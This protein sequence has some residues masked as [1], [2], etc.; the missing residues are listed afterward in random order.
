MTSKDLIQAN[1]IFLA[2]DPLLETNKP[3]ELLYDTPEIPRGANFDEITESV[4]IEDFRPLKGKLSLD[5]DGFILV[6][7]PRAIPYEDYFDEET[8]KAGF[9]TDAK[10]VLLDV[11]GARAVYIHECVVCYFKIMIIMMRSQDRADWDVDSKAGRERKG[12]WRAYT[13]CSR[14]YD[15]I[16]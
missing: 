6:D 10:R 15:L 13:P 5:K 12:I 8:L 3:Y 14:R 2:K 4:P 7:L 11:C 16:P 9:V 1:L